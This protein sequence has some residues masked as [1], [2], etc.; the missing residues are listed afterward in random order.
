MLSSYFESAPYSQRT[1]HFQQPLDITVAKDE[2]VFFK[3]SG[4]HAVYLT[5]NYVV[6]VD[7]GP[8][9]EDDEDYEDEGD[10]M[11]YPPYGIGDESDLSDELDN[12]DNPRFAE[13]DTDDEEE[14][15]P[16]LIKAKGKNKRPAPE[17]DGEAPGLDDIMAKSLK[18]PV[19]STNGEPKLSKK[20]LKKLKNNEGKA[21]AAAASSND[22]QNGKKDS[23]SPSVKKVQ[24]AKD[25]E[26]GPSTVKSEPTESIAADK[27]AD[28]KDETK[29]EKKG[30]A[31]AKATLGVKEVQG[32]SVDDKKLG[33][34]PTAKKGSRVSMRYI[35]KLND[36]KVF[37]CKFQMTLR[38]I[39]QMLKRSPSANKKGKPFSFKLGL[40]EVIKGWEIGIEGISVG[41]ER[42]IRIPARLA[43]G[44]KSMPGI[45]VNS[46]LTFDIKCLEVK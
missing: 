10:E 46:E 33:S 45:P 21:A 24:F 12:I 25:L 20:Q 42:R 38:P 31:S 15:V 27:K 40:G 1:Q 32:V 11:G 16:Q 19:P 30:K 14:K 3:V 17:S 43:Y 6:P 35:G 34:G 7:D 18:E 28:K 44:S 29:D 2:P 4:T 9:D 26:Q 13:I 37:D 8:R 23:E 41:G 39:M 22:T 36:G 5:G